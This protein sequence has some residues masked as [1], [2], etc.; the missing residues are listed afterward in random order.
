LLKSKLKEKNLLLAEQAEYPLM[1]KNG[2]FT[3]ENIMAAATDLW[4][5]IS[6]LENELLDG[7]E[8]V[9]DIGAQLTLA[10]KGDLAVKL[11]SLSKKL[12]RGG[13]YHGEAIVMGEKLKRIRETTTL[14]T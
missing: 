14:A 3:V 2:A 5:A 9:V 13:V 10:G 1:L 4:D 8:K 6:E 12:S 11:H 7:M